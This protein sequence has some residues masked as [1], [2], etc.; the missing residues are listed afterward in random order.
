MKKPIVTKEQPEDTMDHNTE[1]ENIR[2][3]FR[4]MIKDQHRKNLNDIVKGMEKKLVT[5]GKMEEKVNVLWKQGRVA[6][7]PTKPTPSQ[8]EKALADKIERMQKRLESLE[9]K[10][11]AKKPVDL[12]PTL[13]SINRRILSLEGKNPLKRI[14]SLENKTLFLEKTNQPDQIHNVLKKQMTEIGRTNT[15]RI[16]SLE[17]GVKVLKSSPP[18]VPKKLVKK[19]KSIENKLNSLESLVKRQSQELR[20][21]LIPDKRLEDLEIKLS[22]PIQTQQSVDMKLEKNIDALS[23]KVDFLAE[24]LTKKIGSEDITMLKE[25]IKTVNS[26]LNEKINSRFIRSLQTVEKDIEDKIKLHKRVFED[27]QKQLHSM[28]AQ[29]AKKKELDKLEQEMVKPINEMERNMRKL[30]RKGMERMEKHMRKV[31]IEEKIDIKTLQKEIGIIVREMERQKT[32][33]LEDEVTG[34]IK[35]SERLKRKE[36]K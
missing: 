23:R 21:S 6:P 24:E 35:E 20:R 8:K 22:E 14:K 25:K 12:S 9:R 2:L 32:K 36:L 27:M 4:R 1:F 11:P 3:G 16:S 34:I 33:T 28:R 7:A 5:L 13:N 18:K 30:V 29:F 15:K 19:T 17:M 26:L 31:I 10:R